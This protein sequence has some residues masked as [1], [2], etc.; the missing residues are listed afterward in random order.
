MMWKC[1]LPEINQY[2]IYIS[3]G[4]PGDPVGD[5]SWDTNIMNLSMP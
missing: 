3:T 1:E 5:G 2:D 4:G